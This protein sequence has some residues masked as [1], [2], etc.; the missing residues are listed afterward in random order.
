[1]I[2]ETYQLDIVDSASSKKLYLKPQEGTALKKG[3]R[4]IYLV[5]DG[6]SIIYIG[7]ANNS[8]QIRL[9]RG[10][11][12]FNHYV[13]TGKATGGYKGY[14]W[15]NP[16]MNEVNKL[17]LHVVIFDSSYD[18]KRTEIEAIE[19]ELVYEVRNKTQNWPSCQNEI[20]FSNVEGA[21][22]K[23]KKILQAFGL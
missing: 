16:E 3:N 19:G 12:S 22:E 7:E 9:R 2:F 21:N 20:H 10:F 18:S 5:S 14:K 8:I 6:N 23:A 17:T 15:L 1:M 4:K 13:K 11:T